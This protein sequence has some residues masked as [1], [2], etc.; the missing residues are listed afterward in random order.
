MAY[1]TT[2]PENYDNIRVGIV[3]LLKA[4]RAVAARSV[5][6]ITAVQNSGKCIGRM[7][8]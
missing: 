1:P 6:S 4:A 2:M 3:E 5:N 7:L 8:I